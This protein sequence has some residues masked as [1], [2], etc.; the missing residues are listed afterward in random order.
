MVSPLLLEQDDKGSID[1]HN[2]HVDIHTV[3]D[4]L[5]QRGE[6]GCICDVVPVFGVANIRLI[7]EYLHSAE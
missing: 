2:N 7:P 4:N 5:V 1:G 6:L 3:S